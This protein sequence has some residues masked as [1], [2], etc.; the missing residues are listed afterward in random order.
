MS[1]TFEPAVPVHTYERI[2][3]QIERAILSG[4]IPVGA[5][6][7]S[8]RELMVQ[9][10]VSRPTIREALR[11]LQSMGLLESRP[12]TRGGPVVLAPSAKTLS[13]SLRALVGTDAVEVADLVEYRVILEGSA[14]RLAAIKHDDGQLSRMS[15]AIDRMERDAVSNADSFADADLEFHEAIWAAS[16]NQM[17]QLS[18]EAVAGVLLR[19]MQRDAAGE[20]HD[21]RVK[22]ESARIDRGLFAAIE[23]RDAGEASRIARQAVANRFAPLLTAEAD[24]R[25]LAALAE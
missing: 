12:G 23:Q 1:H 21:N 7:P 2:V 25:A 19:L 16:G 15:V 22:L 10:G 3:D 6:L 4:E 18:G 11:I 24:R 17:L 13:R 14:C 9:F 8:E 5:Q 20:H